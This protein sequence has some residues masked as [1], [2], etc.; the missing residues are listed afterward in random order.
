MK[1][2]IHV[3]SVFAGIMALLT[4]TIKIL[5]NI[6]FSFAFFVF[7]GFLMVLWSFLQNERTSTR[8]TLMRI[9]C[10]WL[11]IGFL[12]TFIYFLSNF[13]PHVADKEHFWRNG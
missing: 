7:P 8:A 3:Y 6:D 1:Q 9:G 11:S 10:I 2:F 13:I 5:I 12:G 4:L